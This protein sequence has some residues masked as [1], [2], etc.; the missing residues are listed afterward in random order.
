MIEAERES[1]RLKPLLRVLGVAASSWYH[2]PAAEPKRPGPARKPLDEALKATVVDF[3]TKNPWWGYKRLAIVLRRAGH[4]VSKKF[5]HA[6]FKAEGLMQK[7]RAT[8]AEL[9]QSAKLFELLPTRPNALWQADVTYIHIP[10][11][12]WWY[13]VTVIDYFSRYLLACHLTASYS[14]PEVSAAIELAIKEAERLHGPLERTPFLVTDNGSCFLARRFQSAIK[15][16]FR[17]V[18]TRYRTPQQ[19]GLLE[20]FHQTLKREEVYWQLYDNPQ[21]SREKLDAFRQ[22]YNDVRPHWALEPADGG[23][24]LTPTDVYVKQASIKLP[25]WQGWA[26]GAKKKLDEAMQQDAELRRAA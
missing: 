12:G 3:A 13:A 21:D 20:R 2:R 25:K 16:K 6:V 15:D 7:R 4:L 17:H 22:R 18:R 23:D 10:G 1:A 5:V 9:Y 24:A 26:K 14:A 19:L 11:Y 8:K